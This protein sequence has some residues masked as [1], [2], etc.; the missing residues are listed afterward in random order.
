MSNRE[1]K[2]EAEARSLW[3]ANRTGPPPPVGGSD[4]LDLILGA[5]PPA[6]YDRLYSPHLRS[7]VVTRPSASR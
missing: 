3:A 2:I 6:D 1:T 7:G 5:A 4:L